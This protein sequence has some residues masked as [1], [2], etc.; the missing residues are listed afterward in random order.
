MSSM[1]AVSL[2]ETNDFVSWRALCA[3]VGGAFTVTEHVVKLIYENQITRQSS[4]LPSYNSLNSC[5]TK[6]PIYL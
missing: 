3:A 2:K 1:T 5:T 4:S 6:T